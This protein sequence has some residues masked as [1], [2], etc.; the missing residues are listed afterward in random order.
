M[1]WAAVPCRA[2]VW[3]WY[4]QIVKKISSQ[5]FVVERT[6]SLEFNMTVAGWGCLILL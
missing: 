6:G 2:A 3:S 4:V 1:S 5:V